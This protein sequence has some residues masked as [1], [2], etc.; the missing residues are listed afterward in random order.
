[1]DWEESCKLLAMSREKRE[2]QAAS[3]KL[4]ALRSIASFA[5]LW[6]NSLRREAP[7]RT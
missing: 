1:M 6:F 5:S 7:K 2:L 3:F 4:Q